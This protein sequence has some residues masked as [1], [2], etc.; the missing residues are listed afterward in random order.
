MQTVF[1]LLRKANSRLPDA[2]AIVDIA[3][4]REWNYRALVERVETTAAGLLTLGWCPG[5]RVA[6][7][8]PNTIDACIAILALHRAGMVPA[9]INPRLKSG[10]IAALFRAGG[11][12]GCIVAANLPVAKSLVRDWPDACTITVD[13][14]LDGAQHL[15]DV[16][17][18]GRDLPLLQPPPNDPAFIFY[19][20]GTTGLPKGVV[21]PQRA[22]EPRMLFMTTQAGLTFGPHNRIA[23]IMPLCHVVGFFAVFVL[24][25]A[26]NGI[27]FL[28]RDFEPRTVLAAIARHR[29][30]SMFVTPTHLDALT[31]AIGPHDDLSSLDLVVF[32]GAIMPE[33]VLSRISR[34]LPG[35]KVNIYGT[36]EAMNSLFMREPISG[37]RL[38]PGFYSEVRVVR[39]GG[40][41]HDILPPGVDGE[42]IISV[43]GN[44]AA[45]IEYL[46]RPDATREKL[47]DG[48]YRTSDLAVQLPDGDVEIRGRIDDMIISGGE[49][50]HP[51]EIEEFLLMHRGIH[52][53]AV[54]GIPDERWGSRVIAFVVPADVGL[55][56]TD[57]DRFCRE[58]S[59]A[60]FKRPRTY[61]FLT[62]LPRNETGK[63]MRKALV[64]RGRA[65]V[66]NR[67]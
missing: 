15:A 3:S 12:V 42:L 47:Q 60:D 30:T 53:V 35:R 52:D 33:T 16:K 36:T 27:Y 28:F 6:V 43:V 50:I 1:E 37:T 24:A 14:A 10:E 61:H 55:S 67:A 62:G 41:V 34:A 54:V 31:A 4:G 8:S 63:V 26:L 19:T 21:I 7:V 11:M 2:P 29:L 46:G 49:N 9:L 17:T 18:S 51:E 57:L 66:A 58:G 59:L 56:A 48:W 22:T 25:L 40:T 23:G 38:R 45:F 39:T 5:N 44:D 20:S 32:A 65:S 13:G 64:E